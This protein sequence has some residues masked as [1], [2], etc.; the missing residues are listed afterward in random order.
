MSEKPQTKENDIS[1]FD[2]FGRGDEDRA[3]KRAQLASEYE[4]FKK[5]ENEKFQNR[6]AAKKSSSSTLPVQTPNK[7]LP[8]IPILLPIDPTKELEHTE[9]KM[10]DEGDYLR[11]GNRLDAKLEEL[12]QKIESLTSS[13]KHEIHDL[14]SRGETT[15]PHRYES[16]LQDRLRALQEAEDRLISIEKEYNRVRDNDQTTTPSDSFTSKPKISRTNLQ[17]SESVASPLLFGRGDSLEQ[18]KLKFESQQRYRQEL[19]QQILETQQKRKA[20]AALSKAT[21]PDTPLIGPA[22]PLSKRSSE[23]TEASMLN[24]KAVLPL[25]PTL[26]E[27]EYFLAGKRD[28]LADNG[29]AP[30]Q[31]KPLPPKIDSHSKVTSS[32][33]LIVDQRGKPVSIK[34]QEAKKAQYAEDLRRQ[35]EEAKRKKALQKQQ[36]EEYDRKME[37]EFRRYHAYNA[38]PHPANL[39]DNRAV[40]SH[41]IQSQPGDVVLVGNED[42]NFARGGHGV[43]GSPLTTEQKMNLQK[44]KEDLAKQIEDK[45]RRQEEARRRE[46]ELEVREAERIAA[47]QARM[48]REF[49]AEQARIRASGLENERHAA[50][51]RSDLERKQTMTNSL[52]LPRSQH[53]LRQ[54]TQQRKPKPQKTERPHSG[55][56]KQSECDLLIGPDIATHNLKKNSFCTDNSRQSEKDHSVIQQ[57]RDLRTQLDTEKM[58]IEE[59]LHRHQTLE[60]YGLTSGKPHPRV[61]RRGETL[62]TGPYLFEP[63]C[64]WKYGIGTIREVSPFGMWAKNALHEDSL[65]RMDA[66]Q[67]AFLNAQDSY[68]RELNDELDVM[69]KRELLNDAILERQNLLGADEPVGQRAAIE[70][71]LDEPT[72]ESRR[73]ASP[74]QGSVDI[75]ELNEKNQQRLKRL[76]AIQLLNDIDTDPEAVLQRF[77]TKHD[78]VF[79]RNTE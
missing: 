58:R 11:L 5:W 55:N 33:N 57:L 73:L 31:N 78:A 50:A 19:E 69:T 18:N 48:Q 63:N 14:L 16:Q 6:F 29:Q 70:F 65:L 30:T 26:E 23:P 47:E 20:E 51:Q 7:A 13:Y 32:D 46:E 76:E 62:F 61:V 38:Q 77:V 40:G 43:F 34:D 4:E 79:T 45:R 53:Q 67:M 49:E 66:K 35:I 21:K 71:L 12:T 52:Q 59:A 72:K 24:A 74:S 39:E 27:Q 37:E 25:A 56:Q 2:R 64:R 60:R 3:R 68:L 36:D 17:V 15:D 28:L 75:D 22:S 41:C 44:Y 42:G 8:P 9:P 10:S 54:K 1:F